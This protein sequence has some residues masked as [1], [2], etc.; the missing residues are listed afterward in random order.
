[1]HKFYILVQLQYLASDIFFQ[2]ANRAGCIN[3]TL[4]ALGIRKEDV[5]HK[6]LSFSIENMCCSFQNV[7]M[8]CFEIVT[9]N[10]EGHNNISDRRC[11]NVE[12]YYISEYSDV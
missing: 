2:H 3:S 4:K 11:I 9:E 10:S 6:N 7:R 5:F 12:E 8:H 1:V